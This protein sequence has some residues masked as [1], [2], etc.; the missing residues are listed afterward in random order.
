MEQEQV[1]EQEPE[2]VEHDV[3]QID[4][5]YDTYEKEVAEREARI[6]GK[7]KSHLDGIVPLTH[8]DA[9]SYWVEIV[10]EQTA[11]LAARLTH[12]AIAMYY[13]REFELEEGEHV[14]RWFF[15]VADKDGAPYSPACLCVVPE[16]V[17]PK[18]SM[19]AACHTVG[20]ANAHAYP[21][22][23]PQIEHLATITGLPITPNYAGT[24]IPA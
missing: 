19:T 2:L 1:H 7:V 18:S 16:G 12:T 17:V 13:A 22:F 5:D 10:D 9:G 24:P 4:D 11:W 21:D 6:A 14:R 8:Y 23:A 3:D 15:L 20:F